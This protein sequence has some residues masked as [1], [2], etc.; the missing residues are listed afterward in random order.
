MS[1]KLDFTKSLD[2]LVQG[3]QETPQSP[4]QDVKQNYDDQL[5]VKDNVPTDLFANK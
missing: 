1:E 3:L 5:V 4:E 2:F